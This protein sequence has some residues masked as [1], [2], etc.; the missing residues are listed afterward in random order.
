MRADNIHVGFHEEI[1]K[2]I[3]CMFIKEKISRVVCTHNE[4]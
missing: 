2:I 1:R 4:A 3:S